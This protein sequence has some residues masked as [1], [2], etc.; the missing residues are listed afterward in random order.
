M[1]TETK[2]RGA[3]W[4]LWLVYSQ[5]VVIRHHRRGFHAVGTGVATSLPAPS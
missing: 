2:S 4:L 3:R 1:S 5:T